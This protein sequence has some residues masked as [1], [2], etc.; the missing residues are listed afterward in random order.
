MNYLYLHAIFTM[1]KQLVTIVIICMT[2]ISWS[3]VNEIGF[4]VGGTNY[5][6][7]IGKTNYI[8]P[9]KL[10]FGLL[11]KYNL[12]PRIALRGSLSYLPIESN[13]ASSK[14]S[15]RRKRGYFFNN[16]IKELTL[17][18]EYNFFEFDLTSDDKTYTPF[19]T[20]GISGLLFN[21]VHSEVSPNVYN[22][23]NATAIA[24]PFGV[25]FKIKVMNNIAFGIEAKARYSFTDGLDYSAKNI[26]SLNFGNQGNDW[27]MFSGISLIYAFGR[28]SCYSVFK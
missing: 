9:N 24:I 15:V 23:K 14:N 16:N 25:G 17:G 1:K 18:V 12:N 13:D 5:I 20:V 27:Y 10:G 8:S 7:D 4:T 2:S 28:P 19:I 26:T 22:Y 11:Y 6:G 3:Q 21:K